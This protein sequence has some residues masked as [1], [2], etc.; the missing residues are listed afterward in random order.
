MP[1]TASLLTVLLLA[2]PPKDSSESSAD[3]AEIQGAQ[4]VLFQDI[5]LAAPAPGILKT[6][7]LEEGSLVTEDDLVA[8]LDDSDAVARKKAASAEHAAAKAQAENDVEIRAAQKA[9]EVAK[10]EVE[11][12][13]R[14]L[15]TAPGAVPETEYRRQK[16]TRE[17]T[18]LKIEVAQHEYK[19]AKL[20]A[21]VKAAQVDIA[22]NELK[23][24]RIESPVTGVVEERLK[25]AGEW[26][27]QGEP[28]ARIVQLDRVKVQGF[29]KASD[30]SRSQLLARSAEIVVDL[31]GG[32]SE[33]FEGVVKF[34]SQ[35][36]ET[37]GKYRVWAEV[38]NRQDATG[39][40]MLEP[41]RKAVMRIKARS[42][43]R[44][45]AAAR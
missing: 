31:P 36:I 14:I 32:R 22:N 4:V 21:D 20:T 16:L 38:E 2:G 35:V 28:I 7:L 25:S 27:T 29:L 23:H 41:G 42:A 15:K 9:L 43:Y 3:T 17:N 45:S 18:E 30:Y 39:Q 1:L 34:V 24:R 44:Q 5:Q 8:Q 13:R 10:A 12:T 40:W 11:D 33:K 19:V 26:V 37:D 6:F